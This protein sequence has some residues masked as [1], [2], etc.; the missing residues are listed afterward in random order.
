MRDNDN[1]VMIKFIY[2]VHTDEDFNSIFSICTTNGHILCLYTHKK[3]YSIQILTPHVIEVSHVSIIATEHY[4]WTHVTL[5]FSSRSNILFVLVCIFIANCCLVFS[6]TLT[7]L[8]ILL[9]YF[10]NTT[11]F[12]YEW[13]I[14]FFN[15][16]AFLLVHYRDCH[17]RCRLATY[18]PIS[19][20]R[21]WKSL[22][23]L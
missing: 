4:L 7:E 18:P 6:W 5:I 17:F 15:S 19:V 3:P 16:W 2:N 11:Y 8:V 23:L 20:E 13:H 14:F 12:R 1:L 10:K 21:S 9:S 22:Q